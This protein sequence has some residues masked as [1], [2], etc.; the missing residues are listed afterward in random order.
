MYKV[1]GVLL[2]IIENYVIYCGED[3]VEKFMD[4]M[5]KF[6]EKFV[7]ILCNLKFMNFFD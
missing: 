3:V 1:V 4:Y 2:E 6:E 7:S 5:V